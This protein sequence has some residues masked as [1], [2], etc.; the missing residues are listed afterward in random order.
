MHCLYFCW[1]LIVNPVRS[2]Q[3]QATACVTYLYLE[4]GIDFARIVPS[5]NIKNIISNF[6]ML[7]IDQERNRR[8]LHQARP[9][10]LN[11]RPLKVNSDGLWDLYYCWFFEGGQ[12]KRE[13]SCF[14]KREYRRVRPRPE[15]L[16]ASL[17]LP[18]DIIMRS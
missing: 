18:R 16:Q 12:S 2:E 3:Q 10:G 5:Q 1:P 6:H 15:I 17:I 7:R 11:K 14:F 9:V 8:L 13:I 4:Y